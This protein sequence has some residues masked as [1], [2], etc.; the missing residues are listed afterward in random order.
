MQNTLISFLW[1]ENEAELEYDE[2][3]I[4]HAQEQYPSGDSL[5]FCGI[6]C[7]PSC[8]EFET[9]EIQKSEYL[10]CPT[11]ISRI[12]ER[13]AMIRSLTRLLKNNKI[14]I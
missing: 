7:T 1:H 10:N 4:I 6:D 13:I 3:P 9:R 2:T 12:K 14:T 8:S 5:T 11:C